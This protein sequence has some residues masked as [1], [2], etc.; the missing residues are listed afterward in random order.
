MVTLLLL[1]TVFAATLC[2]V[3]TYAVAQSTY[4]DKAVRTIV[5]TPPGGA[6]DILARI[7][8]Q[9]LSE[10]WG[11]PII[12]ENAVGAAGIVAMDKVAKS[13]PDGYTLGMPGDAPMTTNVTLYGSLPYDPLRD[14]AP[15]TIVIET[16][17]MLVVQPSLP[18][19][20]VQELI[21]LAKS[22]PGKLNYA[23]G[24]SGTSQHL[25]GETLK[26]MAGV[27]ILHI[28]YK[29][30]GQ[31][32]Q[33]VLSGDVTMNFGNVVTVLPHVREGKLRALAV[34]SSKRS[35]QLEDSDPVRL[36]RGVLRRERQSLCECLS[37]E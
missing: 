31:A 12:I 29:S 34:T 28:P 14:F 19:R 6:P 33:A 10:T 30:A 37:D 5:Q 32:V 27:D 1:R 35:L 25:G 16:M 20:T 4:P 36:Q 24:G 21:A 22:Q 2:A 26:S 9:H 8:G 13:A 7:L 15:I 3:A 17:N 11:K 23:T 18:V